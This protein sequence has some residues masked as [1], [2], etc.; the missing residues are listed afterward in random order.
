M[1]KRKVILIGAGGHGKVVADIVEAQGDIVEGFLDDNK[2][3]TFYGYSI[4]GK[5]SEANNF[6]DRYFIVTI[7]NNNIR[8]N[9]VEKKQLNW[10][11]AIHPSAKIS[12]S[13]N[14]GIGTVVMPLVVINAN[15]E[16]GQH[17]II[18]S[19]AIIEHDCF[20]DD[21]VHIS[22]RGV[23]CGTVNI[24]SRV[25]IGAGATIINNLKIGEEI[26]IGAGATVTKSLSIP[27]TY[28]GVPAKKIN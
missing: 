8:K 27:G 13:V 3:G 16:I 1:S 26:V 22:P 11:S 15:T 21:F 28:I 4:L 14:V 18:N 17:T 2:T 20:V 7:G 19:G 25:W 12:S 23:L 10:I 6:P 9:I 24:G 5:I